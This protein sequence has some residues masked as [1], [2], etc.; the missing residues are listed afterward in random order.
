[1]NHIAKLTQ[2]RDQARERV[3]KLEDALIELQDYL[4]SPKFY[5]ENWVSARE[6]F[7]RIQSIRSESWVD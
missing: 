2:Q 1:M 3:R 6:M 4:A 7:F 5:D